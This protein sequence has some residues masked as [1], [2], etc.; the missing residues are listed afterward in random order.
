MS[1]GTTELALFNPKC[2][3]LI[4][5]RA[6]REKIVP[7]VSI[8][9]PGTTFLQP[10]DKREGPRAS[11]TSTTY[12]A[13]STDVSEQNTG[14]GVKF[15]LWRFRYDLDCQETNSLALA[16]TVI[17][18][19]VSFRDTVLVNSSQKVHT[20]LRLPHDSCINHQHKQAHWCRERGQ[21]ARA[22]DNAVSIET[23]RNVDVGPGRGALN[24]CRLETLHTRLQGAEGVTFGNG[25]VSSRKKRTAKVQNLANIAV[26]AHKPTHT[27]ITNQQLKHRG[28]DGVKVE[29]NSKKNTKM[30]RST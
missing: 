27:S 11:R 12:Q 22:D 30:K 25:H 28:K 14:E 8:K 4:W 24:C 1:F 16:M 17:T 3:A 9:R 10:Q 7:V 26:S 6:Q 5:S 18:R 15:D 20:D 2:L 29:E 13:V 19:S 21:N 23:I